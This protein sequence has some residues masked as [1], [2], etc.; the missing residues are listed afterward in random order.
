MKKVLSILCAA[1]ILCASTIT[2]F[3]AEN[4]N[5][6]TINSNLQYTGKT[7]EALQKKS[8]LL[9]KKLQF[10]QF[11]KSFDEKVAAI[12]QN[13]IANRDL[14]GENT[15]LR[16]DIVD[17]LMAIK[18]NGG[19]V[20]E[21][22]QNQLKAY[23]QQIKDITAA[24]KETK[25]DIKDILTANKQNIKDMNYEAVDAA[26]SQVVSIQQNRAEKIANINNILKS[27]K[28]LLSTTV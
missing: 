19:T 27:M 23:K 28:A 4:N 11:K 14:A 18:E 20:S 21:E 6:P 24:L 16:K 9:A 2:A 15:Q 13:R 10:L 1:V 8:D 17:S 26:Y 12:K 25:G 7:A 22:I 5:N 3:A